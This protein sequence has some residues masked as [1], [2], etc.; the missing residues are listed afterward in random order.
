MGSIN[1]GGLFFS[2]LLMNVREHCKYSTYNRSN[3]Y[4]NWKNHWNDFCFHWGGS[5]TPQNGEVKALS[6]SVP[7]L[8]VLH[9]LPFFYFSL[10][11]I[12]LG[13]HCRHS[14]S[15]WQK[16]ILQKNCSL[17]F[18]NWKNLYNR[19]KLYL[20]KFFTRIPGIRWITGTHK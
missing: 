5:T 14:K 10:T 4:H 6:V 11:L 7:W 20:W 18:S 3:S 2:L 15:M 9:S 1:S 13:R 17:V 19:L 12:K 8:D 16:N